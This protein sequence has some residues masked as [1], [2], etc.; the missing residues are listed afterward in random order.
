MYSAFVRSFVAMA[1]ASAM[2]LGAQSTDHHLEARFLGLGLLSSPPSSLACGSQAGLVNIAA[3]D[4]Y[5]CGPPASA[6]YGGPTATCGSQL[7]GVANIAVAN[8][9]NC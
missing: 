7:G 2:A 3:L 4:T 6:P 8:N 5:N 1:L 9:Y